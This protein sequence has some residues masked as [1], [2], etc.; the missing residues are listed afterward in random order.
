MAICAAFS[1]ALCFNEFVNQFKSTVS[2]GFVY[3]T[4]PSI[5]PHLFRVNRTHKGCYFVL[6]LL[7][8][9]SYKQE[10]PNSGS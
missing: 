1:Q 7:P 8:Q 6:I 9:T 2:E 5:Q 3:I 4:Y 10:P